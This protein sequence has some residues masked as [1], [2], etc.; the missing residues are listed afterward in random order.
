MKKPLRV[1]IVEDSEDD[2]LLLIRELR[3]GG[4]D[5]EF[6][7]VETS[8]AMQSALMQKKWDLILSDYSLPEFDAPKALELLKASGLD[9]PF[10][11]VSGTIGEESAVT[12][13]KAGANDFLLKRNL[14]R[15]GPAIDRELREAESRRE[16]RRAEDQL[17]YHARL[18][19]Y[20]NDAVIATDDQFRI[21]AWNRAAE[22]M[23]GWSSEE[24]LGRYISE[25]LSGEITDIQRAEAEELLTQSITSRDERIYRRKDGRTIYVEANTIALTDANGKMTGFVSVDRDITE[26]RRAQEELQ[27]SEQVLRLFVE[28][29]PASIAMF[30]REMKYIVTSRRYLIDYKLGDQEVVGRSHYEIFPEIPER[31]RE[32]HRRCLAGAVESAE[33]DPFP[34]LSGKLDWVRWEI[35]PWYEAQGE[36]GG[37][38]LFSEVITARKQAE[39]KFR[40]AIEAAPNA[41]L[42]VDS[43]GAI[44]LVNSQT[45]KYFGYD[46]GDLIGQ[47]VD[48][49]VPARFRG[50]H[51][52]FR[53]GFLTELG[54]RPIGMGRDLFGL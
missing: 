15:L 52:G 16:R 3:R 9:L 50:K 10:I 49:L 41:I 14:A 48:R 27:R 22:R 51:A 34:R 35:R 40:L 36:I 12:A 47:N 4:Y 39:E 20:I 8:R 26:R 23:Y 2:A 30:D 17:N 29:S 1:L 43:S 42:M 37:I 6:E 54:A 38:I 45:E 11:L 24:V 32:I 44:L 19:R 28:H 5:V 18:L 21:T 33:E 31:W 25:I 46:R 13:L 7:R 53:A